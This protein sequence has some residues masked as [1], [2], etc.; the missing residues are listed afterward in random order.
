MTGD[1]G[2]VA[3]NIVGDHAADRLAF[4]QLRFQQRVRDDDMPRF[5]TDGHDDRLASCALAAK[6]QEAPRG[7]FPDAKRETVELL[8]ADGRP[9]VLADELRARV[10]EPGEID[11]LIVTH[12]LTMASHSG[13]AS[14]N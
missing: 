4:G 7:S 13:I 11:G 5:L 14:L 8:R 1:D 2:L 12:D 6:S 10:P 9:G 3:E